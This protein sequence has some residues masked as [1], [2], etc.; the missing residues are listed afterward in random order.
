MAEGE[1]RKYAPRKRGEPKFKPRGKTGVW[2]TP[3]MSPEN[4]EKQRAELAV[5]AF[6]P[7]HEKSVKHGAGDLGH[8]D[9]NTPRRVLVLAQQ[10]ADAYLDGYCP[11]QLEMP[12]FMPAVEAWARSE[13]RVRLLSDWV[14][15]MTIEEMTSPPE[16]KGSATPAVKVPVELLMQAENQAAKRRKDLGLDP[17]SWASIQ[18]DLGIAGRAAD[19][20]VARMGAAGAAIR[21]QRA[22][23]TVLRPEDDQPGS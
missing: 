6:G 23:V 16:R 22:S 4:Q 13:A 10:F 18:K 5:H 20:A 9:R 21:R 19:D 3:A 15:T 11:P 2:G 7:G 17:A 8:P 12:Q 1:G 14:D